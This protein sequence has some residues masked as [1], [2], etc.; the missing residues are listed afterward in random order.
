M[1]Q[2]VSLEKRIDTIVASCD[3]LLE[4]H[5]DFVEMHHYTDLLYAYLSVL[6]TKKKKWLHLYTL[7]RLRTTLS[8]CA[9]K[10]TK[11]TCAYCECN[12]DYG[13]IMKAVVPIRQILVR[14]DDALIAEA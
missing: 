4:E 11:A 10:T 13:P 14:I 12:W 3:L 6:R 8:M 5:L 7:S 2:Y 1:S 9:W